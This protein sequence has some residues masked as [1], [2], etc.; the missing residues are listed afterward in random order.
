MNYTIT[1][2]TLEKL[3]NYLASKPYIEVFNLVNELQNLAKQED[4]ADKK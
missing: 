4:K 3:L 1:Q 2:Q